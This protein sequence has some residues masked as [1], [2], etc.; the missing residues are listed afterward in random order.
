[1]ISNRIS[2]WNLKVPN[3]RLQHGAQWMEDEA[4]GSVRQ[5]ESLLILLLLL[6][7]KPFCRLPWLLPSTG[8]AYAW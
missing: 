1:M 6:F 5:P 4:R 2:T 8:E 7:E 3:L